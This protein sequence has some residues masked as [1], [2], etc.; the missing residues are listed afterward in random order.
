MLNPQ[1]DSQRF[2]NVIVLKI[3]FKMDCF[4]CYYYKQKSNDEP[5]VNFA[6]AQLFNAQVDAIVNLDA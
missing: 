6:T 5:R 2:I 1:F 3:V 4:Y